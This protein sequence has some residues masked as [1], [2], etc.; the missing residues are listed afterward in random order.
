MFNSGLV[1]VRVGE[2]W[3]YLNDSGK[4]A[5]IGTFDM[6]SSMFDGVGAVKKGD[7]WQL[8]STDG[9]AINSDKYSDVAFDKFGCHTD[10][11]CYIAAVGSEYAVYSPSGEKTTSLAGVSAVNVGRYSEP[12]AYQDKSSGLWG[13]MDCSGNVVI[14]PAFAE[15]K[16]FSN[17]YAAVADDEGLWGIIDVAGVKVTDCEF[18]FIGYFTPELNCIVSRTAGA[19]GVLAFEYRFD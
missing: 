16:G 7:T 5:K 8:I 18:Y 3:K 11:S 9:K 15:A 17:G 2:K 12:F 14:K 10:G 4:D 1:P 13:Y 6:A 19:M